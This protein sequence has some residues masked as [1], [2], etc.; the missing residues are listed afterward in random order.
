[1]LQE[2]SCRVRFA[3]PLLFTDSVIQL[4][5][6]FVILTILIL[7]AVYV[8]GLLHP[9]SLKQEQTVAEQLDYFR[10]LVSEGKLSTE[11]FRKI[12]RRLSAELVE[13]WENRNK[14]TLGSV[15]ISTETAALLA[16]QLHTGLGNP[17]N[18]E[19]T[20]IIGRGEEENSEDTVVGR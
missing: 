7:G 20:Q 13:E 12:K 16:K 6:G 11:E 4:V 10:D 15:E 19:D 3:M 8:L 5:I 1:M 18:S 9:K 14:T 2:P 17:K